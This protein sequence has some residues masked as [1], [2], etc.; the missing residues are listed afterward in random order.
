MLSSKISGLWKLV[1]PNSSEKTEET[2]LLASNFSLGGLFGIEELKVLWKKPVQGEHPATEFGALLAVQEEHCLSNSI[3]QFVIRGDTLI[4][5]KQP[6]TSAFSLNETPEQPAYFI[7]P[8]DT[9]SS[10][11]YGIS[12]MKISLFALNERFKFELQESRDFPEPIDIVQVKHTST[13]IFVRSAEHLYIIQL[14]NLSIEKKPLP[15]LGLELVST[16]KRVYLYDACNL[17]SV[18]E[19]LLK[20]QIGNG[21]IIQS[22]N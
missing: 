5:K 13:K 8:F 11:I 6:D 4:F 2:E 16:E 10:A 21:N 20:V 12:S 9:V 15:G 22:T 18:D 7:N 1:S 19:S 17:V 3:V 14:P